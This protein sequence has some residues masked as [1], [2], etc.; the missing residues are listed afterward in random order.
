M[1]SLLAA[2][3]DLK[4]WLQGQPKGYNLTPKRRAIAHSTSI[5]EA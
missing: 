1:P 5:S 3:A 4:G 2:I